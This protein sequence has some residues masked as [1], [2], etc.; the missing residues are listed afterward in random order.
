MQFTLADLF[1]MTTVTAVF[2]G[3]LVC[4]PRPLAAGLIGAGVLVGMIVLAVLQTL[5]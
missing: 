1:L 2:L 3:I 5:A 4:L